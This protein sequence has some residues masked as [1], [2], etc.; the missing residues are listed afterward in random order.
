MRWA[1]FAELRELPVR[2]EDILD[3]L[4]VVSKG[5]HHGEMLGGQ[6]SSNGVPLQQPLKALQQLEC[7]CQGG[8][9]IKGLRGAAWP[10]KPL[11]GCCLKC[12]C[13]SPQTQCRAQGSGV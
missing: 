9:V 12:T 7:G 3:L 10:K 8:A 6:L 5:G 11:G 4:D 1:V 13:A 2:L